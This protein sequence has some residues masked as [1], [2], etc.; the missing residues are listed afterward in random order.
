MVF[1]FIITFQHFWSATWGHADIKDRTTKF[2]QKEHA[3]VLSIFVSALA[4]V[5]S[6][7]LFFMSNGCLIKRLY[8]LPRNVH[9]IWS[10]NAQGWAFEAFDYFFGNA[11]SNP[12]LTS[13]MS[14]LWSMQ[15]MVRCTADVLPNKHETSTHCCFDV[16]PTSKTA[17]QP[18]NNI[19]L[20]PR[21]C[22]DKI[23]VSK[24]PPPPLLVPALISGR[25]IFLQTNSI[26]AKTLLNVII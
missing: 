25:N 14:V 2:R 13:W 20:M 4:V 5:T 12:K 17:N 24:T 11:F 21:V 16:G 18:Y 23:K 1:N 19:E 6:H 3:S 10:P 15:I 22:W 9:H 8:F 26:N 7:T